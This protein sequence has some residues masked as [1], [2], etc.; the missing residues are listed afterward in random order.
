MKRLLLWLLWAVALT[1]YA[2]EFQV[3]IT[4]DGE[5]SLTVFLPSNDVATGRA[6]VCLPGGGYSNLMMDYEGT[7]WADYFNNKG[8]ALC[9]LKYRMPKGNRQIPIFDAYAAMKMVRDS[10]EV[11][12]INAHDVGIMGFSAGGHLASTVS[13]HAPME[14][15]PDFSI[16]FYPVI[17]MQYKQTHHGSVDNFLGKEKDSIKVVNDFSNDKAVR[18][19]LTPPA[20]VFLAN[21]DDIVPI[22][23]NGVAYF[24]AMHR[25][26]NHCSLYAYPSGGHGFGF[27]KNFRYHQQMLSDLDDWL[28]FLPSPRNHAV[29][30]ACIGNSITDGSGIF[31]RDIFGYPAQLQ[32]KLGNGY[33]VKNFGVGGRT[34]L[35]RGDYPYMKEQAWRDALGFQP[36]IAVIKLGTN[37][38]KPKNWQYGNEFRHDMQQMIDSLKAL[39]TH[40]Q[41]Y[42]CTPIP[43][44]SELGTIL[45]SVIVKEICPIIKELA[46][47]NKCHLIDLHTLY[48]PTEG[49]LQKDGIHPTIKGAG[50]LADFICENITSNLQVPSDTSCVTYYLNTEQP[51][52]VAPLQS[53][54]ARA[55]QGM[56]IYEDY[57]VSVQNKGIA[58]VYHLPDM[59]KIGS[60]FPLGSYSDY[61][62]ANV[63]AFGVEK[64]KKKDALPVLY[65]SQAY[66]KAIDGKKDLCYVERLNLDGSSENVQTIML[67]DETHLYG[68]AL[69]WTIDAQKRRLIGFG[70]TKYNNAPYNELRIIIFPLPK[71]KDGKMITLKASDAIDCYTL[72]QFDSRYPHQ[73]IGQG[74]CVYEDYLIMPTGFGEKDAPSIIYV[75]DLNKKTLV[76]AID[77]RGKLDNEMEDADF[78]Q[79]ELY[80]QTN[81]AGLVKLKK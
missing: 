37:D 64:Y 79:G 54:S 4:P 50:Y 46:A 62:H 51:I 65:V 5:A 74:A 72:Q 57:L 45:D 13:T 29:R 68:Y 80:I 44:C 26:G 58:T 61:N 39:P 77:L 70:N 3:K 43:A 2:R 11:W 59:K 75:W 22:I 52:R 30:V 60:S 35:N 56:A 24:S 9:V 76:D 31:M 28:S 40:P 27:K 10:A 41:I 7:D 66:K 38:S 17:T 23:E 21:D 32:K 36:D 55:Y 19:H 63:A 42:L 48:K 34:M 47:E 53:D 71:L 78:Y 25:V 49:I 6:V 20:A 16:L 8:I 14:L 18:K 1:A 73:V 69:Q 12:H 67:D 81:G 15:R 33:I